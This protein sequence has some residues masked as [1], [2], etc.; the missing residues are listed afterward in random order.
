MG[1]CPDPSLRSD[2]RKWYP[3]IAAGIALLLWAPNLAWQVERGFPSLVYIA[4]HQG[5]G[6]GFVVNVVLIVVYLFFLIP[7]WVAGLVSLF[8]SATLAAHR[9]RM[10]FSSPPVPFRGQVLLRGR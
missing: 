6:G 9:D 3:W 4:N 10:S 5:S 8:R 2:L 7:L 1:S